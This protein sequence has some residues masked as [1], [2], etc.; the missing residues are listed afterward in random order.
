[1]LRGVN[2]ASIEPSTYSGGMG[3]GPFSAGF[4]PVMSPYV[5]FMQLYHKIQWQHTPCRVLMIWLN[6]S[7]LRNRHT[8]AAAF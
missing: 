1:M 7:I 6:Y 3:L 8:Y 5:P 4:R 2:L